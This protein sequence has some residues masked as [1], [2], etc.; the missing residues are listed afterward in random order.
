[1]AFRK[2]IQTTLESSIGD[3]DVIF[4][5]RFVL[6]EDYEPDIIFHRDKEINEI[7]HFFVSFWKGSRGNLDI[8][9]YVGTGKTLIIKKITKEFSN[10]AKADTK[11]KIKIIYLNCSDKDTRSKVLRE[12]AIRLSGKNNVGWGTGMYTHVIDEVID[13]YDNVMVI[14]DEVDKVLRKD[15][16]EVLYSLSNR[17]ISIIN[18]SNVPGWRKYIEDHRIHSRM[19][20][21]PLRFSAYTED[22]LYDILMYRAEKGLKEGTYPEEVIR[23]IAKLAA[24]E[25]GDMRMALNLLYTSAEYAE[26][27]G[28]Q[29][30][31][32][33]YVNHA[34]E[35]MRV[36]TT[37]AYVN[38]LPPPKKLLL[39]LIYEY[40]LKHR[41][42]PT[43][44]ELRNIYNKTIRSHTF[45]EELALQSIRTY[46]MEL[47]TYELIEGVGGKGKGRGHGREPQKFRL[48]IDEELFEKEIYDKLK[49]K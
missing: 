46:L 33:S 1:M 16:D 43:A 20:P 27:L 30:I 45:F 2:S 11:R 25:R 9:G 17:P 28:K 42:Y 41:D 40:W 34:N 23:R 14:L 3:L 44:E 12:V 6:H 22:E 7:T 48:I 32:V 37:I 36:D 38:G 8:Q 26:M 24:Y 19:P 10:R 29:K 18:I 5:N 49:L 15:G 35:K 47:C 4:K 13:N 39:L 31:E 21:H